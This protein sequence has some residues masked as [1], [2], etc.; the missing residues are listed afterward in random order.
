MS[1]KEKS[2]S[3]MLWALAERFGTQGTSFIVSI[4]LTR[5]LLPADFGLIGMIAIFMTM[6]YSL[7]DSGLS[8]SLIRTKNASQIDYSTV[9]FINII[10]SLLIYALIYLTA[11]LIAKFYNQVVLV[12]LIRVYSIGFIITAFTAIQQTRLTKELNFKVQLFIGMPSIVISG[13][14]GI[15]MAHNGFG[16]W[17]LVYM[18]LINQILSSIQFWWVS[19][20]T[21]SFIFDFDVLQKHLNFGYK[22]T[23]SGLL[24]TLFSNIHHVIIGRM[25]SV[26]LLGFYT[27]S[28]MLKKYPVTNLSSALNKVTFPL[29]SQIQDDP[30]RLKKA[31]KKLMQLVVFIVAPMMI[32]AAVLA[33]PL[34]I[35]LFTEKWVPAVPFFQIMCI[36]GILYPLHSYNLNIL[37]VFGRSDL[38]LKLEVVKK[39]ILL[40]TVAMTMWWGI[41]PMLIGQVIDSYLA[42][43]INSRY[44]GKFIN[45]PAKEQL[46]DVIGSFVLAIVMGGL[47]FL[48]DLFIFK[49]QH[50]LLRVILG[51]LIGATSYYLM[52]K[53][54][55]I[56]AFFEMQLIMKSK[57]KRF[58]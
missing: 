35:T 6:G 50:D 49:N 17:S 24:N 32:G 46:S 31:Y 26:D 58:R 43:W 23:L 15:I 30:I 48:L 7:I 40:I 3:S 55:K 38:F 56:E 11:P 18:Y 42:Y 22:I 45:Y 21:P 13:I 34:F 28:I 2:I 36:S 57:I 53:S 51:F 14:F 20:W 4:I 47:I 27:R 12:D 10:G 1:L 8:S 5:V 44:S 19:K 16:V 54:F 33:E 25:Y 39:G 52:S 37:K 41:I 9:F 29:F